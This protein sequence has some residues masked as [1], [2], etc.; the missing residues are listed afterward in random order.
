[1]LW[2]ISRIKNCPLREYPYRIGQIMKRLLDKYLLHMNTPD[3]CF[4]DINI[5]K[6][7]TSDLKEIFPNIEIEA[8]RFS[9]KILKHKF[10]I[11]DYFFSILQSVKTLIFMLVF[12]FER[13]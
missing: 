5:K 2:Y 11:F 8:R 9:E 4:K 3:V 13:L 10:T 7:D 1:M 6:S 12:Y